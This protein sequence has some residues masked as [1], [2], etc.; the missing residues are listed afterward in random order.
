MRGSKILRLERYIGGFDTTMDS[1]LLKLPPHRWV[2]YVVLTE[3]GMVLDPT[4]R[5]FGESERRKYPSSWLKNR[6]GKI[7]ETWL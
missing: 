6:W 7:Y 4:A 2:H 5:Q 1:R 3:D